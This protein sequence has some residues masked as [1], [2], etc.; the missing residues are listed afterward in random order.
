MTT[1]VPNSSA[2]QTAPLL[3]PGPVHILPSY[4]C[5]SGTT[6]NRRGPSTCTAL[7]WD[8]PIAVLIST[9][10]AFLLEAWDLALLPRLLLMWICVAIRRWW[11]QYAMQVA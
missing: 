10:H 1:N 8:R 11:M 2:H 6:R 5:P 4:S 7:T 9:Y 3:A